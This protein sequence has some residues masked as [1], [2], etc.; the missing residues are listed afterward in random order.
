MNDVLLGGKHLGP[1]GWPVLSLSLLAVLW[2]VAVE[3]PSIWQAMTITG[4]TAAVT[5]AWIL[6]GL[7]V[8]MP[9]IHGF[10]HLW[11]WIGWR[12]QGIEKGCLGG[13]GGVML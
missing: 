5:L 2:A 7:L 8:R 10:W 4:S 11:H 13:V 1:T 6:P 9:G 12:A 3:V